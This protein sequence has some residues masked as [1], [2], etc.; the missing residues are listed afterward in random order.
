MKLQTKMLAFAALCAGLT[1][2]SDENPWMGQAGQGGIRMQMDVSSEVISGRPVLRSGEESIDVPAVEEFSVKLEKADGE[3]SKTWATLTEFNNEP[4]FSTGAYTLTAFYGRPG[5]E[6]FEN[7]YFEGKTELTVLE[8]RETE[9]SLQAKLANAMVE[10]AYTDGFKKYFSSY[11]TT[12]QSA[13]GT[14]VDFAQ[15]EARAAYVN[16][17]EVKIAVDFTRPNGKG[18]KIEPASFVAEA[19][20]KYKVTL[21]VNGGQNGDAQ[22]TVSFDETLVQED[23]TIDLT[24][25]LFSS[26]AP[27]VNPQGF[28]S[29]DSIELLEGTPYT[30]PLKYMIVA[31]GG[32]TEAN[33]SIASVGQSS[34]TPAFGNEI[35]LIAAND[36]QKAAIADMG[37][38]VLGLYKNPDKLASVDIT[39][40][41]SHLPAGTYNITL[42]AK[43]AY[44]RVSE[45]V[46]LTVQVV[47]FEL[48]AEPQSGIFG[49]AEGTIRIAYNGTDPKNE[50]SFKALNKYGSYVDAPIKSIVEATRTRSID[51][52]NYIVT[53]TLPDAERDEVPVKV[54]LMGREYATVTIKIIEPEYSVAADAFAN[55]MVLKVSSPDASVL[56]AVV[57][58]LKL[59]VNGSKVDEKNIT[60]SA[61]NNLIF[62]KN[63]TGTILEPGKSYTLRTSLKPALV[64][65]DPTLSV[66]TE[67]AQ[68]IPNGDLS[69]T[70]QTINIDPINIG[71]QYE[72]SVAIFKD[73]Y[74]NTSSIVRSE[75]NGWGSINPLTCFTGSNPMNTWFVAPSTWVE[76]GVATIRTVGYNH[77]GTIPAQS[78]GQMNTSYYCTNSPSDDQ[79]QKAAGEMFL[80][81]NSESAGRV[82]GITFTSRPTSVSF[83]YS[84][85]PVNGEKALAEVKVVNAE[86][87]AIVT[88]SQELEAAS[89][90]QTVTIPVKRYIFG[91]KAA[92]LEV[93]FKSSTAATP[94]ITIPTGNALSEGVT[95]IRSD[96]DKK[97]AANTYKAVATGSVLQVKNVKANY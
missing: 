52:K 9:I 60:R 69:Q 95:N 87:N 20:H 88:V 86:G 72:V 90:M 85:A 51:T 23:V 73:T 36:Q 6:G 28:A 3:F 62:V 11:S 94:A 76:N 7:P 89:A 27:A 47:A 43:D 59:Y 55:R 68:A 24:E 84:Y 70:T 57:N 78:G 1:A 63:T 50:L 4:G 42:K 74:Q 75:A 15:D 67:A 93:R 65:T 53:I 96:S 80:G 44:T 49:V 79:F 92:K 16:P 30:T 8:A 34:W 58:N 2:C 66:T 13:G 91:Q 54:F 18:A 33:L 41:I 38:K 25:E 21:D 81:S 61:G 12:L 97:R 64:D 37:M 40:M 56:P 46:T 71:G 45:A 5:E 26:P 32:L 22:L 39:G 17:G 29:G 31:K 14:P 19:Q 77:A 83:D 82:D 10:I 48:N 35:N